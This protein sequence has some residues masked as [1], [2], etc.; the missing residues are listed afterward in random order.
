MFA[1]PL[2]V[3]CIGVKRLRRPPGGMKNL[4]NVNFA[5]THQSLT[6]GKRY[7]SFIARPR[8]NG[9]ATKEHHQGDVL[10]CFVDACSAG[11]RA[12]ASA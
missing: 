4:T 9:R 11:S 7:G 2:L 1:V 8:S 12:S 6:C 10:E 5:R 3:H